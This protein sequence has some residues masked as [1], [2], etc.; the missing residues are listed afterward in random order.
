MTRRELAS[1]FLVWTL[2]SSAIAAGIVAGALIVRAIAP[3]ADVA[4][5][6][7]ADPTTP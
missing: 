2:I 4:N 7:A 6:A 1:W 3:D 5:C